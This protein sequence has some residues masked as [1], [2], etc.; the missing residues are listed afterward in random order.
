MSLHNTSHPGRPGLDEL[1]PSRYA[2]IPWRGPALLTDRALNEIDFFVTSFNREFPGFTKSPLYEDTDT[3]AVRAGHPGKRLLSTVKGFRRIVT[4]PWSVPE[5]PAM[6]STSGSIRSACGETS[7]RL[8][9]A[10]CLRCALPQPQISSPSF[11]GDLQPRGSS[12]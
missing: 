3:L 9:R 7:S 4:Y 2:L 12:R 10:I 11:R 8:R 6:N 1:V 5:K